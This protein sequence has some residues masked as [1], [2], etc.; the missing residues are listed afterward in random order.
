MPKY[1]YS[2]K[3]CGH[4]FD[5]TVSSRPGPAV[6]DCPVCASLTAVRQ[7]AEMAELRRAK[8]ASLAGCCGVA[9]GSEAAIGHAVEAPVRSGR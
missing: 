9:N 7:P 8:T 6:L 3:R 5:A 4:T 2:C 1:Q